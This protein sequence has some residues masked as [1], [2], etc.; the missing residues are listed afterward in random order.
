MRKSSKF[1]VQS[2]KFGFTLVEM[3]VSIGLFTAVTTI[4]I[5][6]LFTSFRASKKSEVVVSIKQSG[7]AVLTR[8]VNGI[9]YARSLDDPTSCIPEITVSSITVTAFDDGQTTYSCPDLY[10]DVVDITT[11]TISSNSAA[12]IDTNSVEVEDC[13]FTCSQATPS[14]PPTITIKFRLKAARTTDFV[15]TTGSIPFQTSVIMRNFSR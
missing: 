7:S 6:V 5:S 10:A 1:K 2:S 12:L 11:T 13:S 9:R 3:L 8:M 15:E 14:H 4:I